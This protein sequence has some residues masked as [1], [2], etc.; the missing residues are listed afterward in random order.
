METIY[1]DADLVNADWP[2]RTSKRDLQFIKREN[3]HRKVGI[4][5]IRAKYKRKKLK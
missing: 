3:K 2:K 5:S 4:K 1:P